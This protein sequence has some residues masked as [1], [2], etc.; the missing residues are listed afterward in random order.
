MTDPYLSETAC[1]YRLVDEY[2]RYG[3]LVVAYD[4]DN[5]VFDFHSKGHEYTNVIALLRKAKEAGCYLIVFTAEQDT[6]AIRYFLEDNLIPYDAINENPP[7]FQSDAR[8]IYYNIL[9]DD[10]AG[11]YS[12][13]RQL[14]ETL[15]IIKNKI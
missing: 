12:A 11:L 2:K 13:Y 1:I 6:T 15:T 8:K 7:F 3:S 4:Y 10:R 5:C 9:L 14:T